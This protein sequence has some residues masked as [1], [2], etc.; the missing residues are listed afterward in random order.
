M[1]EKSAA[2][3]EQIKRVVRAGRCCWAAP[4]LAF[5]DYNNTDFGLEYL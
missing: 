1:G 5:R 4:K 3:R 2:E